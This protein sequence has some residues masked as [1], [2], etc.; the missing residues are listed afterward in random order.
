MTYTVSSGTLNPI[1][2]YTILYIWHDSLY[3]L[4][5]YYRETARQSFTPNFSVHP[6]G[7]TMR[8]IEND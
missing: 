4:Q 2:G 8:W 6:V 7:K 3:R 1:V 5:S